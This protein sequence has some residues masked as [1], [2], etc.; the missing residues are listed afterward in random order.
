MYNDRNI[1]HTTFKI[2][3]FTCILYT[4]LLEHVYILFRTLEFEY[5]LRQQASERNNRVDIVSRSV[6]LARFSVNIIDYT[7]LSRK[8]DRGKTL[9]EKASILDSFH[10]TDNL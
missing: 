9:L 3:L 10:M 4:G 2:M 7:R 1:T 6:R 8:K 5:L